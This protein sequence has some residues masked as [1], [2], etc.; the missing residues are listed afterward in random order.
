[1]SYMLYTD[2]SRQ[3]RSWRKTT[4]M[5]VVFAEH[6]TLLSSYYFR[7]QT[8]ALHVSPMN[9][10]GPAHNYHANFNPS[11]SLPKLLP[12]T[13]VPWVGLLHTIDTGI[14]HRIEESPLVVDANH[15]VKRVNVFLMELNLFTQLKAFI[16]LDLFIQPNILF[17]RICSSSN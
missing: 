10:R 5:W 9:S 7:R 11:V 15:A 13:S 6:L 2:G 4:V 3:S 17:N 1:M 8:F 12:F 14:D 16:Q